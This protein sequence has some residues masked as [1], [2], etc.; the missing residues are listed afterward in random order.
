MAYDGRIVANCFLELA[1]AD[2]EPLT[3]LKLQKLLYYAHGWHLALFDGEPLV[4]EG[5]QAWQRGPVSP[6]VYDAFSNFGPKA[7]NRPA[8]HLNDDFEWEMLP[9][10]PPNDART[11]THIEKMWAMYKR[12][13]DTQLSAATHKA[14]T[15]WD[16]T[17]KGGKWKTQRLMIDNSAIHD[18]FDRLKSK[19]AGN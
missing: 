2:G 19:R 18:Y 1:R 15:P 14:G 9:S 5:F 17:T 12:Y 4:A 7:I 10:V 16:K 13:P 3:H 6:K 8:R 11:R